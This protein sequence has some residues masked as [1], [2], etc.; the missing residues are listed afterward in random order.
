MDTQGRRPS[1]ICPR[2]GEWWIVDPVEQDTWM[3]VR[4]G[5]D[6]GFLIRV[7]FAPEC[8]DCEDVEAD[9]VR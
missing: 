7:A 1:Y 6:R 9:R 2:C 4:Y 8:P 3:F 5:D